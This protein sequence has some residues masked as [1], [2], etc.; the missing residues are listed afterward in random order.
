MYLHVDNNQ[1]SLSSLIIYN[2]TSMTV[3]IPKLYIDSVVFES[4]ISSSYGSVLYANNMIVVNLSNSVFTN[5]IAVNGGSLYFNNTINSSVTITGCQFNNNRAKVYGGAIYYDSNNYNIKIMSSA[6]FNNTAVSG[7][8]GGVFLYS[9]NKNIMILH[10]NFT[11]N[12]AYR[13][14]AILFY[15]SLQESVYIFNSTFISN[16][17]VSKTGIN[18]IVLLIITYLLYLL[19]LI[20]IALLCTHLLLINFY[21]YY[22]I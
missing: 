9:N 5:S 3:D 15:G 7:G 2:I 1:S 8:G 14:G 4:F 21:C 6:F 19:T 12:E 10:T 20:Q 11:S 18:F 17:A 16:F 22:V 13:A